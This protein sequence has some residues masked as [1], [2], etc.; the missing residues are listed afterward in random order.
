MASDEYPLSTRRVID[1]ISGL[2]GADVYNVTDTVGR[3]TI[4]FALG[5]DGDVPL[6]QRATGGRFGS[7][8]VL[9]TEND[10]VVV[11]TLRYGSLGLPEGTDMNLAASAVE[12]RVDRSNP[13]VA[14]S[15]IDDSSPI[16]VR[17]RDMSSTVVGGLG[18][19]GDDIVHVVI[20]RR[21]AIE[22]FLAWFERFTR[23]FEDER[24][25]IRQWVERI[26][27]GVDD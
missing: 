10:E 2:P 26:D 8:I 11:A 16:Y 12:M 6:L 13:P 27:G 25:A 23:L 14:V 15:S 5:V 17:F 4:D 7:S 24:E 19:S 9:D 3:T 1:T 18:R 21:V 20:N 22:P